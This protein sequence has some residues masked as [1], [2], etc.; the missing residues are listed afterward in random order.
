MIPNDPKQAAAILKAARETLD[1]NWI[2]ENVPAVDA[3]GFEVDFL[4]PKAV[5]WSVTGALFKAIMENTA[6]EEEYTLDMSAFCDRHIGRP[7]VIH[8]ELKCAAFRSAIGD[9]IAYINDWP[10]LTHE[11]L[12]EVFDYAVA[13]VDNQVTFGE[14]TPFD[15]IPV[16]LDTVGVGSLVIA[17]VKEGEEW[18]TLRLSLHP[19]K[20]AVDTCGVEA[21]GFDEPIH[22]REREAKEMASHLIHESWFLAR[23]TPPYALNF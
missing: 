8:P 12:M 18:W 19:V 1:N 16:F 20:S 10:D 6:N 5:E 4:D 15:E 9:S 23:N 13:K 2:E 22:A 14:R 21:T 7:A 11:I 17:D 3:E